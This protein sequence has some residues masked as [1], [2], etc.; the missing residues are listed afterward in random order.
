MQIGVI[1][2]TH[3]NM[4]PE[5]LEALDGSIWN[6]SATPSTCSTTS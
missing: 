4:R 6:S 5:A 1:A 2:D 3:S